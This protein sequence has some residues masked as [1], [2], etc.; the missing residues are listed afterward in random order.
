MIDY[1]SNIFVGEIIIIIALRMLLY[2][3]DRVVRYEPLTMTGKRPEKPT[4]QANDV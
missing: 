3:N 2:C 4:P 1:A